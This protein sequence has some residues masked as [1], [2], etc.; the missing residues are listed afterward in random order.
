MR[1]ARRT[2]TLRA[3]D[4]GGITVHERICSCCG[5]DA[6]GRGWGVLNW[7]VISWEF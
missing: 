7:L 3:M 1:V 4:C 6:R 5:G 2:S